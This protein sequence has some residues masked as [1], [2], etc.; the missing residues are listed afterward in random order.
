LDYS[1]IIKDS[2]EELFDVLPDDTKNFF[3]EIS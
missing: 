1:I 2:L 3:L